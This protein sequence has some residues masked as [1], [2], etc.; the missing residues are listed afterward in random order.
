MGAIE[1]HTQAGTQLGV[2]E[3]TQKMPLSLTAL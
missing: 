2:V 1:I 3:C